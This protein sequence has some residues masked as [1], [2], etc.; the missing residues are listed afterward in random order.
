MSGVSVT[1][2]CLVWSQ[3]ITT[4]NMK[5]LPQIDFSYKENGKIEANSHVVMN[6]KQ[7]CLTESPSLALREEHCQQQEHNSQAV[8]YTFKV[9]ICSYT[10]LKKLMVAFNFL[11]LIFQL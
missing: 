11:K 7:K 1:L 5:I 2:L 6:M 10:R 4:C 9:K 3:H 8:R